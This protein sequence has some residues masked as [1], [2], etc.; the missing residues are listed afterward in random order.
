MSY[1]ERKRNSRK[2]K[3]D[4]DDEEDPHEMKL[5]HMGREIGDDNENDSKHVRDVSNTI[6]SLNQ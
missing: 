3:F 5:T 1:T 2:K 6:Y 4:L